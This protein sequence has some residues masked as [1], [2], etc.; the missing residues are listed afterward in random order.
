MHTL[1]PLLRLTLFRNFEE[2]IH[3][4]NKYTLVNSKILGKMTR[5]KPKKRKENSNNSKNSREKLSTKPLEV[6]SHGGSGYCPKAATS[7]IN[8]AVF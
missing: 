8:N 5:K 2:K 7:P 6:K 1:K 4:R 3:P